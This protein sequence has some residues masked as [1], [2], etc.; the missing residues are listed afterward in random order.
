M[1]KLL[2][3]DSF[4]VSEAHLNLLKQAGYETVRLNKASATEGELA[5]AIRGISV[6]ILGGIEQVTEAVIAS[7][8]V[9][10]AIIFCGVDY[11]KFIPAADAA[12]KKGIK[13]LNAPGANATAV[14][15]FAVGVAIAMQ[16]ELFGIGR[17]G[18]K[19]FQTT[20]SLQDSTAG[21][22]GGGNVA[23]AIITGISPFRPKE[24]LYANRSPK[25][26]P[27]RLVG[28]EELCAVCDIV[29][30]TL[31]M[32]AGLVLNAAKVSSLRSGCLI[33]SVSPMALIDFN[34]L[35][36]RLECGELR[37]AVDWP[38]PSPAFERLP[39]GTWFHV[40]SHSAYNTEAAIR[41]VNDSVTETAIGLLQSCATE[42][43]R[44][45]ASE[46]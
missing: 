45:V 23:Q 6:Y 39:L 22:I 7:A 5:E 42:N 17:T 20:K 19:K 32:K 25:D 12:R 36:P 4:F 26:I 1:N 43:S 28:L 46:Q 21:V 9:L 24:I 31:P 38:A 18:N 13:L 10:Q 29:F 37:C 16:R 44:S 2:I 14:A 3:T 34:T 33:V 41:S 27:A 8:D 40:H 15:E 11:D 30:L 35:L